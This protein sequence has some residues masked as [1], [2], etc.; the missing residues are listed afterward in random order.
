M[1]CFR[2]VPNC[3]IILDCTEIEVAIA[4]SLKLKI[5]TYSHYKQ[6][7]TFK[8]LIGIAPNGTITFVSNLFPGSISDKEITR[9][10]G[11]LN[12]LIAEDLV[13]VDKGFLIS[14]MCSELGV[15]VNIPP[16]LVRPQFT[17]QEALATT[18]NCQSKNSCGKGNLPFTFFSILLL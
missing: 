7:H 1:Q 2:D 15:T 11:I 9:K 5:V 3:R 8:V 4:Q 18:K 16:F 17:V 6:R 10:S 13:L 14:D 12:N